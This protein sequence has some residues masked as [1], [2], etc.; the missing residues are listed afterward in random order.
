MRTDLLIRRSSRNQ[1]R[2]GHPQ[3]EEAHFGAVAEAEGVEAGADAFCG[4]S[5]HFVAEP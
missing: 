2:A 4:E 3:R 5:G 1:T